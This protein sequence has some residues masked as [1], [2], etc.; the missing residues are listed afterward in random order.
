MV[1]VC[2]EE[3]RVSRKVAKDAKGGKERGE[4]KGRR[5]EEKVENGKK[6]EES[7]V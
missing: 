5:N 3:K 4:G 7:W 1:Q 2:P 6:E